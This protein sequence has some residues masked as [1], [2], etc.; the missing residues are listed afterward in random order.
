MK[1][2]KLIVVFLIASMLFF[3]STT[4]GWG[5]TGHHIVAEIAKSIMK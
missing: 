5:R 4:F 3:A 2:Y 1:Q